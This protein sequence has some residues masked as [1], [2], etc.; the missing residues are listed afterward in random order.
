[1]EFSAASVEPVEG[2]EA[3]DDFSDENTC[4]GGTDESETDRVDLEEQNIRHRC[5]I[6]TR[7]V[8]ERILHE[9]EKG[10]SI[11]RNVLTS[12]TK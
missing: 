7:C 1:M 2:R 8:G 10:R 4:D 12:G 6:G 9:S 3:G 5:I 11:S